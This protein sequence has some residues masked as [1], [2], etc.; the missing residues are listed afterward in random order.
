[1][2][3]A[4]LFISLGACGFNAPPAAEA[5]VEPAAVNTPVIPQAD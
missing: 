4:S 3:Y 1:M 5:E 2:R